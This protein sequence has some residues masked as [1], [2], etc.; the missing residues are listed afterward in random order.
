MQENPVIS[1]REVVKDFKDLR[2][3]DNVS[4]DI[5]PKEFV[6]VLGHNGAGKTTLLEMI[7][8]IQ[9]PSS[10]KI[11]ILGTNWAKGEKVL[12]ENIGLALQETRLIDKLSVAETLEMFASFYGQDKKR[13]EEV[14][15]LVNLGFK[16]KAHTKA[17]S[18]G[19]RQRLALGISFLNRPKILLLDE[20][21]TGL[22][23]VSRREVWDVL[24][25][26][27]E[28]YNTTVILTT[29]YMEEASGLCSRVVMMERG[30]VVADGTVEQLIKE[31]CKGELVAVE[32]EKPLA[33][34]SALQHPDI[35]EMNW[36]EEAKK[37]PRK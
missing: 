23:P 16:R 8:G 5:Y 15:E 30:K 9:K 1:V 29:H 32:W 19:Q 36:I 28:E 21:T 31:N 6:G 13:V 27:K 4:L 12:K 18:G 26:Y 3:V 2:A 25:Y 24:R 17:L 22:D 10:G 37:E 7:E 20:P 14:L 11:D 35:I 33:N 34:S